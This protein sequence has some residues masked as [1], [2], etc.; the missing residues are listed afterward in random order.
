MVQTD[1]LYEGE[2]KP[3][4]DSSVEIEQ[5]HKTSWTRSPSQSVLSCYLRVVKPW[6][7]FSNWDF[8]ARAC[9]HF[10]W[11]LGLAFLCASNY[12]LLE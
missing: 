7:V 8:F 6:F 12:L 1:L 3:N 2:R 4:K 5:Q 10:R 11:D 9:C